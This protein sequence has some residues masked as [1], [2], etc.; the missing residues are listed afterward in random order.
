MSESTPPEK[1]PAL[2]EKI[3]GSWSGGTFDFDLSKERTVTVGRDA[4]ATLSVPIEG[5][6]RKH[7]ALHRV[8]NGWHIEDLGSRNGTLVSG[9]PLE[10]GKPRPL[11]TAEP[12]LAGGCSF[13]LVRHGNRGA[14]VGARAGTNAAAGTLSANRE[15][16][17]REALRLTHGNQREASKMLGVSR[18]TLARRMKTFG[19]P[20]PRGANDTE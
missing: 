3:V 14:L 17:V 6:S 20:G 2:I 9:I 10:A 8:R 5:L 18:A 7:F 13:V 11:R 1:D 15:E 4:K 16:G 12:V 19:I